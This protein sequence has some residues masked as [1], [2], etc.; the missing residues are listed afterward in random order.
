MYQIKKLEWNVVK[1][2][3]LWN[4]TGCFTTYYIEANSAGIFQL[5]GI[6]RYEYHSTLEKAKASAQKHFESELL[7]F[8]NVP[9]DT[10]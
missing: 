4:V 7:Q 3:E 9:K 5:E 2:N 1:E 8:L 10:P 6:N